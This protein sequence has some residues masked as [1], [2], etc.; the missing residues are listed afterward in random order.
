M[1]IRDWTLGDGRA[2]TLQVAR[3]HG[4]ER[5]ALFGSVARGDD[6]EGSDCDFMVDFSGPASLVDMALLRDALE[7]L[8][9]ATW[10]WCRLTGSACGTGPPQKRRLCCD[11]AGRGAAGIA[12]DA[13]RREER[14]SPGCAPPAG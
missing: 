12:A 6:Q 1:G 4:V 11:P 10:M 2:D 8:L 3:C 14:A 13:S 7:E 9:A 5:I